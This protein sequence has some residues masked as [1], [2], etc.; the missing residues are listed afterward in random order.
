MLVII[1]SLKTTL[2]V[3]KRVLVKDLSWQHGTFLE[4]A[5]ST[6]LHHRPS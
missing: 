1:T 6:F 3:E 5:L 4:E 2:I